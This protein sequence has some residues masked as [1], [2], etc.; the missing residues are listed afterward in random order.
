MR[1]EEQSGQSTR[2]R[3]GDEEF[4]A[5]PGIREDP[6]ACFI[7]WKPQVNEGR[8]RW[9]RQSAKEEVGKRESPK[10]HKEVIVVALRRAVH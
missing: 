5:F 6:A 8:G 3:K 2:A 4:N 10:E 1:P 7:C 9:K